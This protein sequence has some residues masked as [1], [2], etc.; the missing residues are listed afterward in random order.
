MN[1]RLAL[2]AALITCGATLAVPATAAAEPP[3]P[4]PVEPGPP[5]AQ[6]APPP[7]SA[8]FPLAQSGSPLGVGGLPVAPTIESALGQTP[9]PAAPGQGG[10][11][12][13]PPLNAFNNQ[14]L[15]A[16]HLEPSAP[17][18]GELFGIAPGEEN[19]DI[20]GIDYLKRLYNS[21]RLGGLEGGLLGQRPHEQLGKPLPDAEPPAAQP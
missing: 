2:T 21:Y 19:T 1:G 16:Q 3:P 20:S 4:P 7:A 13:T 18:E 12:T 5:P 6:T 15:L 9:D 14:Y 10:P 11:V 8:L 17:G